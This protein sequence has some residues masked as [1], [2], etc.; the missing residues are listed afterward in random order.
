MALITK[1]QLLDKAATE[2]R[3]HQLYT[4]SGQINFSQ[5]VLAANSKSASTYGTYDIFLSH[6][7]QDAR[8]VKALRDKLVEA[9]FSVYVDWIEDAQ[10]NRGKVTKDTAKVLRAR[11]DQSKCLLFMTSDTSKKSVWMP[12]E[13]G[14][15]DAKTKERVAIAPIVS[16]HEKNNEFRGQEYLGIYPYL[17]LT[18]D[19]FYIQTSSKTYVSITRWIQGAN[20]TFHT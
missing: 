7:Y 3:A 15:M 17:D 12:W 19:T 20:P 10:L 1:S 18:G 14:Y 5:R 4:E 13:L 2:A 9:G 8:V 11:M 6:S 16:D